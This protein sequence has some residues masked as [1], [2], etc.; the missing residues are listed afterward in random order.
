MIVGHADTAG[1]SPYNM[2]LSRQ[3]AE[4]VAAALRTAGVADVRIRTRAVGET[5]L[6]Q[7]TGDGVRDPLNRRVTVDIE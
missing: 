1:P 5:D 2:N 7:P 3:R 4:A 6:A